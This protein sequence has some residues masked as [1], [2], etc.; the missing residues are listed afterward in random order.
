MFGK[1]KDK[2]KSKTGGADLIETAPTQEQLIELFQ[3]RNLMKRAY[4][5]AAADLAQTKLELEHLR[6]SSDQAQKRLNVLDDAL[7][8][9]EKAQS[10]VVWYQLEPLRAKVAAEISGQLAT[11]RAQHEAEE[12]QA[13]LQA[14]IAKQRDKLA[15]AEVRLG[16]ATDAWQVIATQRDM[17]QRELSE[18]QRFWHYFK[19][20][21]L[22]A[23]LAELEAT[24][25]PLDK[26]RKEVIDEVAALKSA[27]APKFPGLSVK[28][29]RAINLHLIATAQYQ[30]LELYDDNVAQSLARSQG[31]LPGQVSF[32]YTADCLNLVKAVTAVTPLVGKDPERDKRILERTVA[33]TAKVSFA[34]PEDTLPAQGSIDIIDTTI[35]PR[36]APAVAAPAAGKVATPPS[37][38]FGQIMG[39]GGPPTPPI[40]GAGGGG[41]ARGGMPMA[42]P[43]ID[44]VAENFCG[45]REMILT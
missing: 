38:G 10:V 39:L 5:K 44:V 21:T 26:K 18:S 29:K 20:K 7:A 31:T 9:P 6:N 17:T 11:L 37:S 12:Q 4:D 35:A 41:A 45:L 24:L 32:G 33:L 8:D 43:R 34:K 28:A 23:R 16:S 36:A 15:L 27:E 42:D 30:F 2:D 3:K 13:H 22:N 25:E 14:F 40:I 19:R 1:G